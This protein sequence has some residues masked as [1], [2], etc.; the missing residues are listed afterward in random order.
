MTI[1]CRNSKIRA[2]QKCVTLVDLEN[3]LMLK[4]EYLDAKI[5][6]ETAEKEP[7]QIWASIQYMYS[8][9]SLVTEKWDLGT[10]MPNAL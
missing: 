3:F 4:N 2:V 6:V 8:F 7:L 5:G 1:F 10:H 9:A